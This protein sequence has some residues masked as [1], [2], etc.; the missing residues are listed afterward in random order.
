MRLPQPVD[1]LRIV[2]YPAAV[3]R[4]RCAPIK[5]FD[6]GLAELAQRMIALM[7]EARGV[8]LA[9]PQVGVSHRLF[10]CNAT[11]QPDDDTV[12]V[13]PV[14]SDLEGSVEADEGCLS[15]P[16]VNVPKRRAARARLRG[17]DVH[18]RP[19]EATATE[20]LARIWQHESDHLN[21]VLVI[22]GMSEAAELANRRA[23]KQLEADY[24]TARR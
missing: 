13:N 17:F 7:H 11:G 12:W 24:A 19:S 6:D 4:K 8:G 3:L 14:L 1:K 18:G 9:A 16:G 2:M 15:I 23:I 20:L 5:G 21:G 10:V 22:D